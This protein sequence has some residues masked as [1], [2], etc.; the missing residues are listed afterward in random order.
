MRYA[1][2]H[3]LGKIV[4][5]RHVEQRFGWWWRTRFAERLGRL[6]P[7]SIWLSWPCRMTCQPHRLKRLIRVDW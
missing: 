2:E 1:R 3:N 6:G 4:I 7:D 5:G